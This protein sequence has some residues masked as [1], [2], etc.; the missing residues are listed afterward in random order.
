[1]L[2]QGDEID[3]PDHYVKGREIEPIDVIEDWQLGYHLGSA[4][5]YIA[6]AGRKDDLVQDLKKAVWYLDRFIDNHDPQAA[7]DEAVTEVALSWLDELANALYGTSATSGEINYCSGE[8]TSDFPRMARQ[9][10]EERD[11]LLAFES[12]CREK[13]RDVSL[14][15]GQRALLAELL[16]HP[17]PPVP[18]VTVPNE[19]RVLLP[20][21]ELVDVFDVAD[22]RRAAGG[23]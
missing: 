3:H 15:T 7:A 18:N 11:H 1:M 16:A 23:M 20:D 8:R 17:N 14:T 5:K 21:R 10:R 13:L 22:S 2:D 19:P 12:R 6:R 9:L 4:L